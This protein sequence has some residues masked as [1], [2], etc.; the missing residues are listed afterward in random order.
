MGINDKISYLMEVAVGSVLVTTTIALATMF[1]GMM[2]T[3]AIL[4]RITK[5]GRH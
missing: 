2:I 5:N 3:F 4:D 1:V